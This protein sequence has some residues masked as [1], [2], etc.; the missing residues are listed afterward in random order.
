M[1]DSQLRTTSKGQQ[2]NGYSSEKTLPLQ[3]RMDENAHT[4]CY[5][6][7]P[8]THHDEDANPRPQ[9][10]RRLNKNATEHIHKDNTWPR[11]LGGQES[12]ES[13]GLRKTLFDA[14]WGKQ[15]AKLDDIGHSFD[16]RLLKDLLESS[17]PQ[18]VASL[19][20]HGRLRAGLLVS[21]ATTQLE[22]YN[23]LEQR[24]QE[25]SEDQTDIL[26]PLQPAHCPNIQTA[27]KTII[28]LSMIGRGDEKAYADFLAEHKALIPMNFDLELL[29]RYTQQENVGRVMISMMDVETFETPILSELIST[30]HS[31]SD[32]IPF[33]LVIGI[34][35]TIELFES[36]FS[37][38]TISLLD[39]YVV[40]TNASQR[41]DEPLF[42]LYKTLQY[43]EQTEVFLGP[44]VVKVLADLADEQAT[45]PETFIRAMKYAYM[46]HFFAN[47]LSPLCSRPREAT[48]WHPALY[49]A[50]RNLPS[51]ESLCETLAEGD[52][53]QRQKARLLL[54]SDKDLK[55]EAEGAIRTGQEFMWSCL[56]AISTLRYVYH[57]VVQLDKYTP[58]ES[59]T[60]LLA[61]LPD[62]LGSDLVKS[63]DEAIR[64][65]PAPPTL[66]DLLR[67]TA[68]ELADF[69]DYV[70]S[71]TSSA[72]QE[73]QNLLLPL[74]FLRSY[75]THRT[76]PP[77]SSPHP[78]RTSPFRHF[79][80]ESYT[81]T[82]RSPLS[83]TIHPRARSCI[84]RALTRP[85]DYLG[86]ACCTSDSLEVA[87]KASL[88][89]TSL[90][91]HMLNE[92]G[93]V[94]NVR[95]LWDA[96]RETLSRSRSQSQ[97]EDE[98]D[99]E[100]DGQG[101][102]DE[103]QILALFYRALAELRYLGWIKQSKRKPGVECI[104]KT[105]WM[106]L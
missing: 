7:K 103:R 5:I 63:I 57:H 106:G 70:Y 97:Q 99:D 16:D 14:T 92:A 84:E 62:L 94:I 55:S 98:D 22:F 19:Q 1:R 58:W 101:S 93:A 2:A 51:F 67:S 45:T 29:Q 77:S 27:L 80:A 79:M 4:A 6:F 52:E 73:S 102:G 12:D 105:V 21:P 3:R 33:M 40:E 75:L 60:H 53:S 20:G 96:F 50:I 104:Q 87:D 71:T 89:P 31:W 30:F 9:K 8:A 74:R 95:D 46:S 28:K 91:L 35:T 34:S 66:G 36:R 59:E 32:R 83:Q 88:P 13:A 65:R 78:H 69:Q 37:R 44:A 76:T 23:A 42:N 47:P 43:N 18:D 15:Q 82:S 48:S 24:V 10:K 54:T 68:A 90:L 49:K 11:L 38:A 39:A 64:F 61:S 100:E 81:I 26:V 86:C 41:G 85:A 17:L 25:G 56:N 72:E